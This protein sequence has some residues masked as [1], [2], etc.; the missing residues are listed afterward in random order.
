M[1]RP[2]RIHDEDL[3]AKIVGLL[4]AGNYLATAARAA[5]ID[6][7][8]VY[9]W[10]ERGESDEEHDVDSPY[11]SFAALAGV[12]R[13]EAVA[14]RVQRI[15]MAG[16]E[17]DW[18]ADT[19]WLERAH[20]KEW[21]PPSQRIEATVQPKLPPPLPEPISPDEFRRRAVAALRELSGIPDPNDQESHDDT[22]G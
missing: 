7:S 9:R 6:P 16:Q 4:R 8:T 3:T 20:P 19:W 15:Q 10:I 11:R 21:G 1:A 2:S 17:G 13:A 5:G 12:A 18:R 22:A 14:I